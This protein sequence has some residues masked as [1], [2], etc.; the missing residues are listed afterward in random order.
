MPAGLVAAF[1]RTASRE[2]GRNPAYT[3]NSK[4]CARLPGNGLR[5][6]FGRR[7]PRFTADTVDLSLRL[8]A[9]GRAGRLEPVD[10]SRGAPAANRIEYRAKGISEWWR[11]LPIGYEQGFTLDKAP[12]GAG[13]VVLALQASAAPEIEHGSLHW[14]RLYY[15]KLHVVDAGGKVLPATL[16]AH[17]K[18]IRLSFDA[19]H[20]VYPV[21]VDPLVWVQQMVTASDAVDNDRFGYSVAL[22][23][24]GTTALIGA[25]RATYDSSKGLPSGPGAAYIFTN[26][27]GVWTQTARLSASDGQRGDEL[28]YSV[29]LSSDGS[30]AVVGAPAA[31]YNA[32][33]TD[34][35]GAVYVFVK[36]GTGW[37]SG[38]EN[39][40]LT[41][42]SG[43]SG[44]W[45]GGAVA[46]SASGDTVLVGANQP[47][48]VGPGAAYV[49]VRP[50]GGWSTTTA[51]TATLNASDAASDDYFGYAVALSGDGANALIGANHK[52]VGGNVY[53]GAVYLYTVSPGT[54]ATATPSEVKLSASDGTANDQFGWSVA[55]SSDGTTALVGAPFK[56]IGGNSS[57]GAAYVY[58]KPG[59]GWTATTEMAEL[60][61][62]D[63]A[64]SDELGS[65]VALSS[66][67]AVAFIAAYDYPNSKSA[68]YFFDRPGTGWV[69]SATFA[70]KVD[71][72]G[73]YA[74]RSVALSGDGSIALDA[75]YDNYY[76]R[77]QAFFF[78]VSDLSAAVSVPS[79]A[80]YG[81][82]YTAQYIVTNVGSTDSA[83]VTAH[84]PVPS[85]T[86]Y[87][88]VSGS[89]S[90][91]CSVNSY[92]TATTCDLGS[93][94]AGGK[95]TMSLNLTATT[96]GTAITQ[97]AHADT[98]PNLSGTG[99]TTVPP[100]PAISGL[101]LLTVYSSDPATETFTI[102][103]DAPLSVAATSDDQTLL[104]DANIAVGSTCTTSGQCTLTLTPAANQSGIANVT[105]TLTD[106]HG[107]QT[108]GTF[109]YAVILTSGG[110]GGT[111]GGGSTTSGGGGG[112]GGAVGLW[113]LL[114]LLG[115]ARW[116][117]RARALT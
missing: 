42:S 76:G 32:T 41:T 45:F 100:L 72:I 27:S 22:S 87:V 93:I 26:Q 9:W 48:Y 14:G 6:C 20:A 51:S 60:T 25:T 117:G 108:Q 97:T 31:P 98:T 1:A 16:T 58:V 99:S 5:G 13:R 86:A 83:D 21:T 111:S 112:G 59:G 40:K 110:S 102:S 43:A 80:L 55:F 101:G 38:A 77:G 95:A 18:T 57:Q 85:N 68:G 39:A 46:L 67:G 37:A 23:A 15:G 115:L 65:A 24:D 52:T 11:A 70:A 103:G 50:S 10:L 53:E 69:T 73:P 17:G 81:N 106:M 12:D 8:R 66:T 107:Q 96:A 30:T 79:L 71:F 7:G 91:S 89:P 105:V 49:Y 33:S 109:G 63:G 92:N 82:S 94:P 47:R 84:M 44:G 61:A 78:T 2:A 88:S 56:D 29:A 19:T 113:A 74:G 62:S 36:P 90:G 3:I 54:W 64:A 35:P 28:G 4:A 75:S 114:A 34:G 116:P 104:P